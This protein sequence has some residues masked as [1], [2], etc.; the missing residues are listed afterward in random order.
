MRTSRFVKSLLD[1][2]GLGIGERNQGFLGP[3]QVERAPRARRIACL[4]ALDV[5]VDVAV[6]QREEEAEVLGVALVRRGRHQ[7]VVVGHLRQRFAQ[8][9]G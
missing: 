6:E 9:V 1:L 5:A 2:A 4:Q 7:Q 8:L 3:A